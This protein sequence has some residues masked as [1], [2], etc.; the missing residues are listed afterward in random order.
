MKKNFKVLYLR[1]RIL[2]HDWL[3]L[4]T[5]NGFVLKNTIAYDYGTCATTGITSSVIEIILPMLQ[6]LFFLHET[7]GLGSHRYP[8][9]IISSSLKP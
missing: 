9:K 2:F 3:D 7:H 5:I 4:C 8:D 6:K 1:R